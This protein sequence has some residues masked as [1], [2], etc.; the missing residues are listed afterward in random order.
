MAVLSVWAYAPM[1]AAAAPGSKMTKPSFKAKTY[2]LATTPEG[3][4]VAGRLSAAGGDMP[5]PP[6]APFQWEGEVLVHEPTGTR[7]PREHMGCRLAGLAP[8]NGG[9]YARG[10]LAEY[11]CRPRTDLTYVTVVFEGGVAKLGEEDLK[12]ALGRV[13]AGISTQES[14]TKFSYC[15]MPDLASVAD[16]VNRTLVATQC[17]ARWMTRDGAGRFGTA[18]YV[19]GR[20]L[21][22][23]A[24]TNTCAESVCNANR[25]LFARFIDSFD[26][27]KLKAASA[28]R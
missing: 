26:Q 12:M 2:V 24:I 4:T 21:T 28:G 3:Q 6:P 1:V 17:G 9:D 14:K 15:A 25:E 18:T 8:L 23:V 7:L 27:S 20:G 19:L 22:Y 11:D 16:H 10:G 5:T 13:A